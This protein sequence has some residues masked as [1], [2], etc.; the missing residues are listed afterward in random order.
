[1]LSA[2]TVERLERLLGGDVVTEEAVLEFIL[3]KYG[4]RH[5]GCLS[6]DVAGEILRQPEE[7]KRK[8]R[9]FRDPE[10]F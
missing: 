2:A 3:T 6:A 5:L 1:M 8:A 10:L 9:R 4:A 7:F